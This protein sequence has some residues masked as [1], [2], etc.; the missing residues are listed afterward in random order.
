M[1]DNSSKLSKEVLNQMA[2]HH[3]PS[4]TPRAEREQSGAWLITK[5][6][7]ATLTDIDGREYLDCISGGT[8]AM[9]V[10]YGRE[11]IAKAMYEQ[12]VQMH[13]ISP[14][15]AMA[16]VTARLAAKLAE[17]TP[18]GLS[19]TFF[20][21][22]GSEAVEAAIKLAKQYHFYNK[23]RKRFK[24]I[25]RQHAY[26]GTTMGALSCTGPGPAFDFL[27]YIN[28]PLLMPGVSH[29]TAPYCYRCDLNLEYPGCEIQC[30]QELKKEI[31]AQGPDTVSAFIG[32]PVIGGGGCIPPVPEYWSMIR[33]ICD[34]YGVLLIA[35][36]VIHGFGSTGKMF[37]CEHWELEPDIMTMAKNI[38]G[39]YFP[40]A[41]T[42][43]KGELNEKMPRFMHVHTWSGHAVGCAAALA[44]IDIIERE[45]MVANAAEVGAYLLDGLQSLTPHSIVG[46]VRGLGMLYGIEIVKDKKTKERF[47]PK[48]SIADKVAVKA[49]DHGLFI[50]AAGGDII[51]MAPVLIITKKDADFI[52]EGLD[53][54]LKDVEKELSHS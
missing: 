3:I 47:P 52:V 31:E 39:C 11:E 54:S 42:I 14:Y 23:E 29:I 33:S 13:Y 19:Q 50:R 24:M 20:S 1:Q 30:A 25:S 53:K 6:E 2:I 49:L 44:T 17:I 4:T 12:A 21:D 41:A 15:R 48:D 45:E 34:E 38:T 16:P 43:I 36:E 37:A 32:E 40:L 35:D 46:E 27:R 8:L 5:A 18:G 7:G 22:S 51:E 26:H 28:E 9:G 10:G